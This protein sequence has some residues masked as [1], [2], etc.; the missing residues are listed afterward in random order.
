MIRFRLAAASVAALVIA[1]LACSSSL[2]SSLRLR[3]I[4]IVLPSSTLMVGQ[5]TTAT[6]VMKDEAGNPV[7]AGE[8]V[9]TSSNPVVATVAAA[10]ITALSTGSTEIA[11][12]SD[13]ATASATL[14]VEP[15]PTVP[16]ATVAVALNASSLTAGQSTQAAAATY[17]AGGAVLTGRAIAW[18]SSNTSVATVSGS[19]LVMAVGGG[20]AQISATSEGRTGAASLQVT[21]AS[22]VGP[23]TQV[24]IAVQPTGAVSGRVLTTQPIVQV[25]DAA[26]NLVNTSTASV[27]ASIAS[28]TGTLVGT[29]TV[30]AVNGVATFSSLRIDGTGAHTLTVAS[31]GLTSATSAA[32]TV[33]LPA[34]TKLTLT[35]QPSATAA[36]G[37]A[38]VTQPVVQLRDAANTAVS[39]S[40]VVVAV[41]IATGGGTLGGATA[42]TDANGV[43]TF[44]ALSISGTN[45]PRTLT[46]SASGL[47]A[48]TSGT[49]TV[50]TP[51]T[52]LTITTQP[53]ASS[54]SGSTLGQQPVIQLRDASNGAVAQAGVAVTVAIASGGG[55]LGGTKTVNTNASGAAVFSNLA[56]TGT[57]GARTLSFTSGTLTAATSSAI[58]VSAPVSDEPV[59][60]AGTNTM[61]YQDNMDGYLDVVSMGAVALSTPRIVPRPSPV[62]TSQAVDARDMLLTTGRSGKA[63]RMSYDGSVQNGPTFLTWNMP[64]TPDL[65]THYFQYYARVTPS[66]PFTNHLAHKWFMAYHR[67][68]DAG[69]AE[70]DTHDHLPCTV[71]KQDT[72]WHFYDNAK[73][74]TCQ[75]QQPV[76]PF[77]N[78]GVAD[79]QWHR[80]TMSYRP[81]TSAGSR[82]G[83]ARM[84]IDGVKVIDVS[85]AAVGV[86]PPG[87]EKPWCNQDDVDAILVADG[88]VNQFFGSVQTSY[89]SPPWTLDIDDY[90]WWIKP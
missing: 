37:V 63:I 79:G 15:A 84:W 73:E 41:A 47:T 2:P 74:T 60:S 68:N 29:A 49:I 48:V 62:T 76:G 57:A 53:S 72:Y 85:Q 30:A 8:V 40:G 77:F 44:S 18:S 65:A 89:T 10:Q 42:T 54:T 36:S 67:K 55:T 14:T 35:T 80:F 19:G 64:S 43:A 5:T 90:S 86:T 38:F 3:S 11:A 34:A 71:D 58:A 6:A 70:W 26:G 46:F 88:I 27:T 21:A 13:G 75:G 45:G 25:R 87:G 1:A 69:R 23:P 83:F 78:D 17:D 81:N 66:A 50:T 82:D 28:G 52:Q 20:T 61:V 51:P 24:A 32:F 39:Q 31:A 9:W 22:T 33:T 4:D 59:F 16:V 12:S 56:I 7:V